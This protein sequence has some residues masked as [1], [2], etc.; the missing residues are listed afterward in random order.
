MKTIWSLFDGSGI[1]AK[2]YAR[3]GVRVLCFNSILA[4]HGGY[5]N[6][7]QHDDN[8]KYIDKWLNPDDTLMEYAELYG[9]PS[10]IISFPP[11]TDLAVSGAAHFAKKRG[12]DPEFQNKAADLARLAEKLGNIYGCGH[13]VEN[14]ISV[15]STLWRKPDEIFNP[16]DYG[17]YLPDDDTHPLFPDYINARDAYPKKTCLWL[18]GVIMPPKKPVEVADTYS[19]QHS[20][21]GGKTL[22]TKVIRSLTPRGFA[23]AFYLSNS[24]INQ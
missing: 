7:R 8:I 11:C 21:L 5:D 24:L 17:G 15:L 3:N 23:E 16:Y 4:D 14:P 12:E 9:K 1:I 22:K 6:V 20:M 19:K 18:S 2:P 13:M 10:L